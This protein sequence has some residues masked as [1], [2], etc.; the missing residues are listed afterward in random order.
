MAQVFRGR[1]PHAL[2]PKGRISVPRKFRD[3]LATFEDGE[4]LIVVPDAECLQIF[5][6]AIWER[7][8]ARFMAKSSLDPRVR[9]FG[10]GYFSRAR[11]V[12]MDGAGRVL[13][14][15][16]SR[17]QAGLTR[18]V[19]IV[20]LSMEHF[21]VWDRGRFEEYDRQTQ[22]RVPQLMEQFAAEL[23]S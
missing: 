15:P 5:P 23:G 4:N 20:G 18:D 2:D 9:E 6:L 1:F 7:L 19:L 3:V 16:D 11:D 14:P 21:E 22:P 17:Q 8:E 13:L 10:R 12:E